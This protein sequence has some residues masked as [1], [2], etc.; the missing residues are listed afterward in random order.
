MFEGQGMGQSSWSEEG[1]C[2]NVVGVS[3]SEAFLLYF[4]L[5]CRLA[6]SIFPHIQ[7][8]CVFGRPL[9]VTFLPMLQDRCPVLSVCNVGLLWPNCGIEQGATWY[10]GRPRPRRHC[11]RRE[12]SS[13][14]GKGHSSPLHFRHMSFR[15]MSI[16]A[17]RSPISATAEL[18]F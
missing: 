12:P 1:K 14:D 5:Q 10:G 2:A 8:T 6:A 9:Q 16:V 3:S 15:P 17:K 7:C 13:A 18:L 11:L 4:C